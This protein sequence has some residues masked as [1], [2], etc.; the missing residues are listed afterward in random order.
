MVGREAEQQALQQAFLGA[1]E[2]RERTAITVV[3]EPGMG[4]S[5][6]IYEFENWLDLQT[7]PVS[8]VR[9]R[10]RMETRG[11]P[12][13]LIRDLFALQFGIQDDD[14][15]AEVWRKFET[16]LAEAHAGTPKPT[17][18]E[19]AGTSQMQAHFLGQLL[20]YDFTASPHIQA[21]KD[22]PAQIHERGVQ[23]LEAYFD[24]LAAV[25]PLLILLEDLHWSDD[26]SLNILDRIAGHWE[27]SPVMILATARPALYERRE[28]WM[29]GRPY[30]QRLD[31]RPLSRRDSR[32]LVEEVLKKVA[33]I[34]ENLRELIVTNAEGNP[35][36]VEEL[37]K[38]LIEQ[39]VILKE[40]EHWYVIP[41]RLTQ[42]QIPPTLTGVLQARLEGLSEAERTL[43]QQASV[44]GRVFWDRAL[45]YMNRT[46][47]ALS[48]AQQIESGLSALRQKEMVYRRENS[49]FADAQELI[50]KHNMLRE[51]AYASVLKRM[52]RVY[53][54][55]TA[56]WLA[57]VTQAGGRVD[58]YTGL[59]AEHYWLAEQP[60]EA[61]DWF[62]RAGEHAQLQG[63]LL[64]A[65]G[66]FKRSL[67]LLPPGEGDRRWRALEGRSTILF[68]M[69]SDQEIRPVLEDLASLGH[70]LHNDGYIAEAHL[71]RAVNFGN[72]GEDRRAVEEYR[73]AVEAARRV[74]NL[75]I[76]ARALAAMSIN[77]V[78]LGEHEAARST[79]E[80]A[81]EAALKVGSG[82]VLGKVYNNVAVT[83][84][85][86]GDLAM[87]IPYL[88]LAIQWSQKS[89]DMPG[90]GNSLSN[91]GY[92]YILLGM[93]DQGR[94]AIERAI[95]IN[96]KMGMRRQAA[97]SGLNLGLARLRGLESASAL[98]VLRES[99]AELEQ[100]G[101]EFGRAA[102]LNY[103]GLAHE[104]AGNPVQAEPCFRQ[105]I[106]IHERIG[107]PA[108]AMD[109][110]AG[111]A[112][113]LLA[114]GRITEARDE[115]SRLWEYL[116][117]SSS[118][119][120]EFP[121]R[122]YLA[123]ARIF[124]EAGSQAESRRALAAGHDQVMERASRISDPVSRGS[125][126]EN[127]AEHREMLALWESG[128]M[129]SGSSG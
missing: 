126:L 98:E 97:Y 40:D 31:L 64:E 87:A 22:D 74:P 53:H 95:G 58:E 15:L 7:R 8:I 5:R 86:L 33:D 29:E 11:L 21:V 6:L 35:Y 39:G 84:L 94:E 119:G 63:A 59:I 116:E 73:S 77:Q 71:R 3:A 26:S 57:E 127:V 36:Y 10:A 92:Q 47:T 41:D 67:E 82:L 120:M 96:R 24:A 79:A 122:A 93:I 115:A 72:H 108:Y 88:N 34:P 91:L 20:G 75:T 81:I 52:R 28:H 129:R 125:F 49:T 17:S 102:G 112:G 66:F 69:G 117:R 38:M 51:A 113:A 100:L 104:V 70:A 68:L 103:Q 105:A 54:R 109:A 12:L 123:C 19:N 124:Q 83:F 56:E 110:R 121:A 78:R 89:G 128:E 37:I 114:A 60:I 4:K 23:Y 76:E 30:H 14:E 65:A 118:A 55:L 42:M 61:A 48:E 101:D 50:F 85:E 13:A 32:R 90:V 1:A 62:V 18:A 25:R 27:D 45:A 80:A 2:D 99:V 107:I 43:I 111:L 46:E 16:G 9:G 106:E 44:V